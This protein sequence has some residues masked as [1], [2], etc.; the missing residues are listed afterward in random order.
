MVHSIQTILSLCIVTLF[1][2]SA[3]AADATGDEVRAAEAKYQQAVES[4]KGALSQAIATR[5]KDAALKDDI[6]LVKRLITEKEA[7]E[8]HSTLPQNPVL[9]DDCKKFNDARRTAASELYRA[10]QTAVKSYSSNTNTKLAEAID[11]KCKI[12]VEKEQA[13]LSHDPVAQVGALKADASKVSVAKVGDKLATNK[14]LLNGFFS[15]YDQMTIDIG[16]QHDDKSAG[17]LYDSW[18][19]KAAQDVKGQTWELRCTIKE[20]LT[21]GAVSTD[22]PAEMPR[23]ETWQHVQSRSFSVQEHRLS[24]S[25]TKAIRPGDILI[26]SGTPAITSRFPDQKEG[27]YTFVTF[28]LPQRINGKDVTQYLR[29]DNIKYKIEKL[30]AH[31]KEAI[32]LPRANASSVPN[33]GPNVMGTMKETFAEFFLNYGRM[34]SRIEKETN[35]LARQDILREWC[36][37]IDQKIKNQTWSIR[38]EIYDIGPATDGVHIQVRLKPPVDFPDVEAVHFWHSNIGEVPLHISREQAAQ[39]QSGD[40]IILF[41]TPRIATKSLHPCVLFSSPSNPPFGVALINLSY[42]IEKRGSEERENTKPK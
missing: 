21:S 36:K 40:N 31:A 37:T 19:K 24:A 15:V 29:L 16:L 32:E 42:F 22:P 14:E 33:P 41:G 8:S 30:A 4:A 11:A 9:T 23:V 12:F 35:S 5:V 10:Y 26:I 7:F 3:V 38:C 6:E 13:A 17:E 27:S 28:S 2:L 1:S 20:V 25:D 34:E 39:I 18:F